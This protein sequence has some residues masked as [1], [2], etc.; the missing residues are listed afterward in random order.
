MDGAVVVGQRP[1]Q[2][3]SA[4][5]LMQRFQL[6]KQAIATVPSLHELA[7]QVYCGLQCLLAALL[8]TVYVDGRKL[9]IEVERFH[10]V[11]RQSA[12]RYAKIRASNLI[13]LLRLTFLSLAI[14]HPR[15]CSRHFHLLRFFEC[16]LISLTSVF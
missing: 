6:Q 10:Y 11:Y 13:A 4:P 9:F 1:H 8:I 2:N 3:S 7:H 14:R 15:R 16:Q 5:I 12:R